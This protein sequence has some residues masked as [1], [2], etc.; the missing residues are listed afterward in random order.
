MKRRDFVPWKPSG[1]FPFVTESDPLLRLQN[2]VNR[3]F[4]GFFTGS[5]FEGE[6]A[7]S[8]TPKVDVRETDEA[9]VVRAELPGMGEKDLDI[10]LNKDSLILRGEKRK[11]ERYEEGS[12][13]YFESSYGSFQR[14]IPLHCEVLGDNVDCSMKDGVLSLVLPKAPESKKGSRKVSVRAE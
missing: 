4:E 11:E 8:F 14:T 6:K 12:G 3:L 2:E 9:I 13:V 5:P 10:T 7:G 1:K